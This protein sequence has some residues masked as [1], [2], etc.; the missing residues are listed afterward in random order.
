MLNFIK[1]LF[2]PGPN[3]THS[4]D[5]EEF[6]EE[7]M[8][9]SECKTYLESIKNKRMILEEDNKIVFAAYM[10]HE[11]DYSKVELNKTEKGWSAVGFLLPETERV[12]GEE[13]TDKC[14]EKAALS[15]YT[16]QAI[17]L[18]RAKYNIGLKEAKEAVEAIIEE[19][20]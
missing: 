17:K 4:S 7:F 1:K 18:Y 5:D 13:L 11:F 20:L 16:I 12:D 3:Q 9:D 19:K 15:G 14:I 10:E 2:T 8:S 6:Q